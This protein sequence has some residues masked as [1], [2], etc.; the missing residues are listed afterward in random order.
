MGELVSHDQN[1]CELDVSR[2][3]LRE[4]ATQPIIVGLIEK[5]RPTC[6]RYGSGSAPSDSD[7]LLAAING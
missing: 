2:I 4:V 7:L 5:S 1:T 6:L 3:K